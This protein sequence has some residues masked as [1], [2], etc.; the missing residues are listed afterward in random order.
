MLTNVICI[1]KNSKRTSIVMFSSTI[2]FPA[3]AN[4]PNVV[5]YIIRVIPKIMLMYIGMLSGLVESDVMPSTASFIRF[6]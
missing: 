3:I 6:I 4:I 1:V 2:V 5:A